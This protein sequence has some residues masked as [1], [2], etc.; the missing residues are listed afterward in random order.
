MAFFFF[1]NVVIYSDICTLNWPYNPAIDFIWSWI[2]CSFVENC[3][4][5]AWKILTYTFVF[6]LGFSYRVMPASEQMLGK[7]QSSFSCFCIEFGIICF[8]VRQNLPVEPSG[9]ISWRKVFSHMFHYELMYIFQVLV[10]FVNLY[11]SSILLF[12]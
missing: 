12:I 7:F 8:S 11:P 3:C 2:Y 4:F 9:S 6:L 10:T 1:A 5:C